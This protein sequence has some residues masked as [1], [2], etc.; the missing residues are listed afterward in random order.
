MNHNIDQ[1]LHKIPDI[2][3]RLERQKS[4]VSSFQMHNSKRVFQEIGLKKGQSVMDIGCGAGDYSLY[5]AETVGESGIVYA[6]DRWE[7]VI[8][9][10]QEKTDKQGIKNIKAMQCDIS[11][12]FTFDDNSIDVCL[13]ATILHGLNLPKIGENLFSEIC[14]VLKTDGKIVTID[15]KKEEMPFGPPMEL[16][17]LPEQIEELV[18]PYG[19][20][21]I[22]YIDWGYTYMMQFEKKQQ[23][24]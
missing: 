23:A 21:K 14:R 11:K 9:S 19:L 5:A 17:L 13:M 2:K 8:S 12:G 24:D 4:G 7:T 20:K 18:K 15:I 1:H 22:Q 16:R 6:I 10:L 3:K